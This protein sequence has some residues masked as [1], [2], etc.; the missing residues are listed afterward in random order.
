MAI[1][2]FQSF[3]LPTLQVFSDGKEHDIREIKEAIIRDFSFTKE[4]LEEML[5]SQ[6]Q[7]RVANRIYWS[8]TYLRKALLLEMVARGKYQI[9][10]RGQQLLAKSPKKIDAKL[11]SHYPEYIAFAGKSNSDGETCE[12]V[13]DQTPEDLIDSTISKVNEQLSDDLLALIMQK[14]YSFFERLVVDILTKMGYGNFKH[15]KNIVTKK[16]G[17][18]GVDGI[19][20]QDRLGLDKI[21]VQAK[22]Y[23]G[24]VPI[25]TIRDFV[26]SIPAGSQKGVFITTSDFPRSATE[27]IKTRPENIILIN[28]EYLA[29]LMVEYGIGT[30]TS[31]V[32]EVKKIDNDYFESI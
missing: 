13:G 8:V 3:M 2:S 26:G 27:Y 28:G 23:S 32:Y 25:S 7:T 4:D 31:H 20:S 15:S 18:G 6:R 12:T 30:Q 19:I 5:P 10:E 21:Y 22:R 17:D 16:T 14:D 24:V 1:P 29:K 11:L 9:T